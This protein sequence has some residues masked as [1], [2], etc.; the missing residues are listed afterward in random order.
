MKRF[1]LG[2]SL[3]P[4]NNGVGNRTRTYTPFDIASLALRVF[5]SAIPTYR[6]PCLAFAHGLRII[7]L[8]PCYLIVCQHYL[9]GVVGN[10][11]LEPGSRHFQCPA[12]PF[13]LISH[14]ERNCCGSGA[15]LPHLG[16]DLRHGL[17]FPTPPVS[18]V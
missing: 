13:K 9:I 2:F 14:I 18:F 1:A 12:L 10:P 6:G 11:V 15:L 7:L 8:N 4:R 5:H 3:L 17:L 16:A